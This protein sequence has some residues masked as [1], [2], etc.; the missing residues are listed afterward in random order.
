[1]ATLAGCSIVEIDDYVDKRAEAECRLIEQCYLGEFESQFSS[2]D[3]CVNVVRNDLEQE[4]ELFEEQECGY[5]PEE[6][7]RC[8]RRLKGLSCADWVEKGTA[9]ACD[10]VYSCP[11]SEEDR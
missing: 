6:A 2:S 9:A 4:G 7:G 5:D 1:M 10:L 3:D 8:V 11:P